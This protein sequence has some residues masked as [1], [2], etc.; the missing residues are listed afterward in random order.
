[1]KI[2]LFLK[3]SEKEA[4]DK[5]F[6]ISERHGLDR[7][8]EKINPGFRIWGSKKHRDDPDLCRPTTIE[9]QYTR[10]TPDR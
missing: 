7:D 9:I 5:E 2:N 6:S 8:P 4:I 1:M 3:G 10:V